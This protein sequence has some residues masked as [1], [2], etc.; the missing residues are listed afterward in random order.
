MVAYLQKPEG[1]EAF[2][3]IVDFLNASHIKYALIENPKIYISLIQQFWGTTTARTTD[4]GEVEITASIDG[5]VKTITE[6]SLRRHLKLEDSDGIT[7][8][9]NTEIFEQLAL[10]GYV[11]DSARLTFQK[12]HFS[13]QW[14]FFIHTILHC[15]SP[16]TTAW[17]QFSSNIATAIICLATNRTFNFSKMIFDAMRLLQPHTRTY[18]TPTLNKNLFSNMKRVSKGYS[19]VDFPLFPTM[20]TTPESS[21]SRITSSPSLSP[22]TYQSPQSSPLRDIT[23]QEAEIPQSQFPT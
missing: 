4:D 8:L 2:H 6:A 20:I 1:S 9:P 23:R 19:G 18:P 12:G 13:P 21:P 5:Q 14:R 22:Q 11:S 16:K 7:S 17:E 15:L 3:Q 10:M